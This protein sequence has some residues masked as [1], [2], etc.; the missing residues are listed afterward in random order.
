[1]IRIFQK[2]NINSFQTITLTFF[3]AILIGTALLMLPI[4]SQTHEYTPFINSLFTATSA[5]CV[6]G[7]V[8][9]DSATHWSMFGQT[10]LLIL[11]QIG[12]LGVVT[13]LT[14]LRTLVGKKI[15]LFQRNTM[16]T[17]LSAPEIQG[18]VRLM[19]FIIRG[20]L[21]IELIAAVILSS[22]F[23]P[24]FGFAKGVW[25]AIF[26]SISA[27]CN[28]GFDLMGI[29]APFS[30]LSSY[31]TNP[32]ITAV[33]TGLI[34]IGGIGFVSWKDFKEHRFQ[35]R[36]YKAQT[37]LIIL[38]TA[39]FIIVPTLYF[40]FLEFS[41][42]AWAGY[43]AF[44]KIQMA[45]FQSVTPRTAGFNTVDLTLLSEVGQ[46]IIICLMLVGG[47]PGS[48]AGGMKITTMV[49]VVLLMISVI[50]QKE[51]TECFDR[52]LSDKTLHNAV[53][54]FMMYLLLFI[55][56]GIL[57]ALFEQRDLLE[58]FFETAS[59]IG[60]VGLTLGIT[61]TLTT[62]S[63]IILIILMYLGR[64]G[65]LTV[66]FAATRNNHLNHAKKPVTIISVG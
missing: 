39:L 47:A 29:K 59:A 62:P 35:Y 4:S 7:L 10:V 41:S 8:V 54:V 63:K 66:M 14:F 11:I 3:A 52:R 18:I 5:V 57:I 19:L 53:A 48:T 55:C 6:T 44:E 37:K 56:G 23:V 9:Y 12:G 45:F 33:I 60:T 49:I 46:V 58:C 31:S 43:T 32:I 27:F 16:Q 20:S 1:M 13:I 40:Y 38:A 15:G 65:G 17:A 34:I 28:A 22:V 25:Y 61:P 36:K 64:V 51:S 24:E 30:S 50:R 21:G 2:M 26:H 42:S